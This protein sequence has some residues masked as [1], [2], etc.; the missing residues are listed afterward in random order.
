MGWW[1]WIGVSAGIGAAAGIFVSGL[2]LRRTVPALDAACAVVL[3]GL[4]GYSLAGP[5]RGHWSDIVAGALGCL[6]AYV[7]AAVIVAGAF[8]RGGTRLG[9]AIIMFGIA[10]VASLIALIPVVGFLEAA[11]VP[12]LAYRLRRMQPERYAGLRTLA[13]D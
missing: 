3:G 11:L 10:F 5:H 6:A 1:Y 12:A 8:K 9:L 7:G 2:P 13:K 4:V